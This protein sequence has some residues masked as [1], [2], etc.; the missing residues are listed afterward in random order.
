MLVS[1]GW[2]GLMVVYCGGLIVVGLRVWF[3]WLV[4]L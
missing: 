2:S 4:L 3:V 1:M